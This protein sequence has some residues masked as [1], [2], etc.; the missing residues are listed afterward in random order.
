MRDR[1]CHAQRGEKKS[2]QAG[3]KG[4]SRA[5]GGRHVKVC[6]TTC[7]YWRRFA[8][9]VVGGALSGESVLQEDRRVPPGGR[10]P[11][12]PTVRAHP[13]PISMAPNAHSASHQ[14]QFCGSS[15]SSTLRDQREPRPLRPS[16]VHGRSDPP[17]PVTWSV[18]V[19]GKYV[20]VRK[21]QFPLAETLSISL[22]APAPADG[23]HA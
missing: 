17:R 2:S 5:P 22:P 16:T 23:R 6:K 9:E 21:R 13:I 1:L 20:R 3:P 18:N 4:C 11:P 8:F 15:Q 19:L 10:Y 7:W 14:A 12:R